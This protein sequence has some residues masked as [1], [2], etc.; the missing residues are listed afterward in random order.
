MVIFIQPNL[1]PFAWTCATNADGSLRNQS[2]TGVKQ[3]ICLSSVTI[4]PLRQTAQ[5]GIHYVCDLCVRVFVCLCS[6]Q[7]E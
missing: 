5:G 1:L 7:H 2:F 6:R 3:D 4:Y